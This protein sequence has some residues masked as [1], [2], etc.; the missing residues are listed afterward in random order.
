LALDGMHLL[1]ADARTLALY[2]EPR[3]VMRREIGDE[4]GWAGRE[5][6]LAFA[7]ARA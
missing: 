5:S 6:G 2:P 1:S 3:A 7:I 4:Q